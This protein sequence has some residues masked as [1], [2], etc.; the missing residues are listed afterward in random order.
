[1]LFCSLF[2]VACS[3]QSTAVS[4]PVSANEKTLMAVGGGWQGQGRVMGE[5]LITLEAGAPPDLIHSLYGRYGI[6]SLRKLDNN[7]Y[8][9]NLEQ[10]PGPEMID[11]VSKNVK[12]IKATQP[13]FT[14]SIK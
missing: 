13:N 14:Y 8:Q 2:M 9:L 3:S 10:D 7:V 1:M 4:A 6:K 11:S 12:A 5:Y